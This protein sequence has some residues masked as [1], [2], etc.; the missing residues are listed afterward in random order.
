MK[1]DHYLYGVKYSDTY[2]SLYWLNYQQYPYYINHL[3]KKLIK[4]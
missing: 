3:H 1:N 4:K 2:K